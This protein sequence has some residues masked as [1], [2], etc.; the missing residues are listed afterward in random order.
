MNTKARLNYFDIAKGIGII[1]VI[2][3]HIEYVEQGVRNYIVSFHMPLFFIISGMLMLVTNE[4][5]RDLKELVIRKLKHIML[6]YAVFS[7]LYLIIDIAYYYITHLGDGW[8]TV[9]LDAIDSLMLYGISVLWFL[10][11]LF[12]GELIFLLILKLMN[13]LLPHFDFIAAMLACILLAVIIYLPLF[14]NEN[15]FIKAFVRFF[16]CAAFV[17]IGYC[18]NSL[19]RDI[20]IPAAAKA[21]AGAV[22]LVAVYFT[23]QINGTVDMHFGVYG[24][25][26]FYFLT[27]VLGSMGVILLSG[28][29]ESLSRSLP[30]KL[31]IY[32][33][34]NSLIVMITHINFYILYVAEVLSF[35][36]SKYITHAKLFLFNCMIVIFVMIAEVFVIELYNFFIKKSDRKKKSSPA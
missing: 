7:V 33:G 32:Y 26:F 21:L 13:R 11:A 2:I 15:H 17:S 22:M 25:L 35:H 23:S 10:P 31:L 29:L 19:I 24:N 12:F 5:T 9:R 16:I 6:V 8:N 30:V 1:L 34:K 4:K 36:F 27:A 28:S 18:I 14:K 20:K 3:G